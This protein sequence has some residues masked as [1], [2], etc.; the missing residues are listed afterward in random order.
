MPRR[1]LR[2]RIP[3]AAGRL[4]REDDGFA[5]AAVL[6]LGVC[7]IA[8]SAVVVVRGT[9]AV[10]NTSGDAR[11]ERALPAAESGLEEG[12]QVLELDP[13][14]STVGGYPSSFA[15]PGAERE[16]VV[17]AADAAG[18][19][20]L[21]ETPV[22]EYV[23]VKPAGVNLLYTVGYSPSRDAIGRRT[24]VVRVG[25]ELHEVEWV[26]E[27]ALL[28]GDGLNLQGN[29]LVIDTND[30]DSANVHANG[31]VYT[32][33]SWEVQGCLSDSLGDAS[34]LPEEPGCPPK[35]NWSE[36]PVAS[37][38]PVL[39]Y[40]TAEVVLCP[41]GKAYSGPATDPDSDDQPCNGD[42][43]EIPLGGWSSKAQG[44]VVTWDPS[45]ATLNGVYYVHQAN[46]DGKVDGT[47]TLLISSANLGTC[48][49]NSTGNLSLA[50]NSFFRSAPGMKADGYDIAVVAQGDIYYRGGATV[51]GMI[52][53]HEQI[54]YRGNS[55]SSGA[56]V[57][58]GAC[59]TPGSPVAGSKISGSVLTGS[60][61]IAY[62]GPVKTPFTSLRL[63]AEVIA[64]HEL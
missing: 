58:E 48:S 51:Q 25:Y 33:G 9:R 39:L 3:A 12:L 62:P 18:G 43:V 47:A 64:W 23:V 6:V 45:K 14:F 22:G 15:S 11:W 4:R 27:Y 49:G 8:L 50:G 31:E 46:V 16:W 24:R 10:G 37:I 34:P 35:R 42:E 28:V 7:L 61:F 13:A 40:D 29:T 1:P 30:N 55:D 54:D 5:I 52:M 38:D 53:A 63:E 57:A 17:A 21:V 32:G 56:V 26:I 20:D 41:D 44:G 59:N 60:S 36:E 2:S 19:E